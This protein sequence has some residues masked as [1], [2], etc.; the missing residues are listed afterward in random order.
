INPGAPT[1]R[2]NGTWNQPGAVLSGPVRIPHLYNGHDKTYFLVAYEHVMLR[3][4][5]NASSS[6]LVPTAEEVQGD[7]SA[8]CP[9][10][11]NASGVCNPGGGVQIYDPLT[12]DANHNRTPFPYN[13]IPAIA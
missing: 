1:P 10:G 12:S 7:F 8:L 3:I 4:Y 5:N 11:F 6:G 13:K 2:P 9:G